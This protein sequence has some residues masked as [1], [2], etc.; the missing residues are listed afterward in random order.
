M[1][2]LLLVGTTA[3]SDQKL[4]ITEAIY[5]GSSCAGNP[6]AT[7]SVED[8][9][10]VEADAA[11]VDAFTTLEWTPPAYVGFKLMTT[12]WPFAGPRPRARARLRSR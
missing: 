2:L 10:C 11:V 1:L 5:D 9:K 7:T 12:R 6:V 4:F 3:A 8:G